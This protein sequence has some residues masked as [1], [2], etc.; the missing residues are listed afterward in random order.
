MYFSKIWE[1][2]EEYEK[3]E[4]NVL[5]NNILLAKQCLDKNQHYVIKIKENQSVILF[6]KGQIYDL[7]SEEGLYTILD[8]NNTLSIQDLED[9]VVKDNSDPLCLLFFNHNII[10]NNKFYLPKKHREKFYG[11]GNF[12]FQIDNPI[13]L[14]NKVIEIRNVYSKEELLEQIR[15]RIAKIATSVIKD[16]RSEYVIEEENINSNIDIFTEYGIKIT[17]SDI[18]NIKFKKKFLKKY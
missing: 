3:I 6:E 15:E 12:E 8:G 9:Y 7:V 11:E 10:T 4:C 18:K 2:D 1:D 16:I 13:K 14:F 5:D 17:S